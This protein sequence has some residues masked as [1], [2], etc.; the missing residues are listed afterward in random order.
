MRVSDH[1]KNII[2][3][4]EAKGLSKYGQTVDYA[5]LTDT[6]WIRHAQEE[7]VDLL[8]YLEKLKRTLG[9]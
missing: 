4:Q 6:E 9:E 1:I 7:I 3:Q 2:D 5:K 8:V